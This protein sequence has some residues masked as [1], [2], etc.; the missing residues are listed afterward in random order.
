MPNN[1]RW[2]SASF[3]ALCRILDCIGNYVRQQLAVL[4]TCTKDRWVFLL[5]NNFALSI[6][7]FAMDSML[8][9]EVSHDK[10]F[11]I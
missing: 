3:V 7:A 2:I 1:D 11:P 10:V 8:A 5:L 9:P 6:I 4:L